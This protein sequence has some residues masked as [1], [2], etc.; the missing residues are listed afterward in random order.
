MRIPKS[1]KLGGITVT[2]EA[3]NEMIARKKVIGEA[4]YN[5]QMI[6]MDMEGAAREITEQSF[7]HELVHW[8]F[9]I[10]G[11]DKLRCNERVVDLF[12]Q[13]LYQYEQSKVFEEE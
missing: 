9:Y 4:R 1:F 13:F 10:M 2:V 8:I 12:A 3:D 7:L 11:E 5:S 6:T